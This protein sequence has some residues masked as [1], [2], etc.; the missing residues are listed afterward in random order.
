[1]THLVAEAQAIFAE[2][3][4]MCRAI[5]VHG[6]PLIPHSAWA[7]AHT[8][9]CWWA[10]HRGDGTALGPIY[11]ARRAGAGVACLRGRDVPDLQGARLTAFELQRAGCHSH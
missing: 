11:R 9:Q 7:R 3:V 6:E 1:M 4:A 5:G 2:D 8:L 10:R